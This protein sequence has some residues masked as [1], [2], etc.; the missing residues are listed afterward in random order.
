MQIEEGANREGRGLEPTSIICSKTP[1][2]HNLHQI[3]NIALN[4]TYFIQFRVCGRMYFNLPFCVK[5]VKSVNCVKQ[6]VGNPLRYIRR[7]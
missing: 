1:V 4:M 3:Y 5:S 2:L 7:R 6:N